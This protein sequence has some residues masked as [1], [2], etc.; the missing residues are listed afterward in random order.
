MRIFLIQ[1]FRVINGSIVI[2]LTFEYDHDITILKIAIFDKVDYIDIEPALAS[3]VK[4]KAIP[5]SYAH[6]WLR[7]G[8]DR[9]MSTCW[10]TPYLMGIN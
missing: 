5:D 9:N 3:D 6:Y 4:G 2:V 1:G 10:G 7:V 8:G